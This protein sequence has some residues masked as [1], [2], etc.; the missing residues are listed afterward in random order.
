MKAVLM[1]GFEIDGTP[2]EIMELAILLHHY[3]ERKEARPAVKPEPKRR[4]RR[5]V[6]H[7]VPYNA[8]ELKKIRELYSNGQANRTALKEYARITGRKWRAVYQ[9]AYSMGLV[10]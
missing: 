6:R 5:L 9:K 4:K 1:N 7:Q 10:R 2:T 8:Y 3:K